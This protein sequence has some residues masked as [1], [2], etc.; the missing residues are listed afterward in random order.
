MTVGLYGIPAAPGAQ[1]VN[2]PPSLVGMTSGGGGA[3]TAVT[4]QLPRVDIKIPV[5]PL[6]R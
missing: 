6:F 5:I 1:P 4:F 3:G 2:P